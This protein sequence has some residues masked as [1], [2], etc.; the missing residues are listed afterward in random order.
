MKDR[1]GLVREVSWTNEN[2]DFVL[3]Q[4]PFTI[5]LEINIVTIYGRT[6]TRATQSSNPFNHNL[7]F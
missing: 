4:K 2:S 7:W 6:L 5:N 1:L 3:K